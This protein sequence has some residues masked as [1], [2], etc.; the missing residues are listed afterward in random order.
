MTE[1][2]STPCRVLWK[3]ATPPDGGH[4]CQLCPLQQLLPPPFLQSLWFLWFLCVAH[5]MS[6]GHVLTSR[7]TTTHS[8]L[9]VSAS[10]S[11]CQLSASVHGQGSMAHLRVPESPGPWREQKKDMV[12]L[13]AC[14]AE[15]CSTGLQGPLAN[16][17]SVSQPH[18]NY[19]SEN[20]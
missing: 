1:K 14:S 12:W 13:F 11:G 16:P 20:K 10:T 3:L 6:D 19:E 4:G 2:A 15:G 5:A 8:Q 18:H 7:P 9:I 17:A